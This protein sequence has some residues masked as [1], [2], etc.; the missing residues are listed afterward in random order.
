MN[1]FSDSMIDYA[2][3]LKYEELSQKTVHDAKCRVLD[4]LGGALAAYTA[5]PVRIAWQLASPIAGGFG[6]R[7]W[8][9]M[10]L[11]TPELAAFANGVM[12]RYLDLNDT[13]RTLDGTHPSD[14][15]SGLLAVAEAMGCGGRD[16]IVTLTIAYEIQARFA[17]SVSF[18][19]IGWDQ[20]VVGVM[21]CAM[22]AG[23]LLGLSRTQMNHAL[24]L[25]VIPNLCTFQTRAGELSMWKAC[26]AANGARQGVFAA[27][28]ASKG[29][30]GPSDPLDG[31][32]GLWAMTVGKRVE[33][34]PFARGDETFAISQSNLKKHPVRDSCQLP[35]DTALDLYKKTRG[36]EIETLR[37][38]TY[39]SA[40]K[41]AVEDPELWAPQ[42]RET[43]DHSMPVSVATVLLDGGITPDSF[44]KKRFLDDD[45]LG[46]VKRTKVEV[47]DDF[48][49]QAPGVRNCRMEAAKRDGTKH[50]AHLKLTLED[51]ARGL[52]DTEIENKI[53][54]LTY[55]ILPDEARRRLFKICWELE[56]IENVSKVVDQLKI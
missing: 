48:T 12:L 47:I 42:T 44:Y 9:S 5:P 41:G 10:T 8:G 29:M 14:N 24:A 45:V 32:Y 26:A 23:R 35:V 38:E 7:V 43:A 18:N 50:V 25:A 2:L 31:V 28:M 49:K 16:L 22:G 1:T 21:A 56:S 17:D 33:M 53:T 3:S 19:D 6:A 20:P 36:Q 37:I 51:I 30:T 27:L 4:T 54:N 55:N 11:T 39:R 46:L 13:H 34:K 52:T 15:L 40:Y